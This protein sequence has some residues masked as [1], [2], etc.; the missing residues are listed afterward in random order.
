M[1]V[2]AYKAIR[3]LGAPAFWCSSR[4]LTLHR[5]RAQRTGAYILAS[6][7]LSPYDVPC[8][9]LA[10]PRDLDFLSIVEMERK[11]WAGRLF[12]ALNCAF[13]DRSQ[14]D[15][16]AARQLLERLEHGR[17]V[18]MFPEGGIRAEAT[19][20]VTGGPIK[21]GVAKLAQRADVPI[22]PCV[23][24][25]TGVFSRFSSWLPLRRTRYGVAF[26][27][28]IEVGHEPT[29]EAARDRA[30]ARLLDAYAEL[31]AELC[32]GLGRPVS[33]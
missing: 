18:A 7:H 14:P 3:A 24:L 27:Q 6:C 13:L 11:P 16:S 10:S 20:A 33:A 5:E 26:G 21:P 12:R 32:H 31:Y 15:L 2:L 9:M 25:G 19:S 30:V 17:V 1:S 23:A 29:P 28:P 8:L 4:P 22:V